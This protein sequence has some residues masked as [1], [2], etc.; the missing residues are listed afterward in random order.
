MNAIAIA[1]SNHI[2]EIQLPDKSFLI[3]FRLVRISFAQKQFVKDTFQEDGTSQLIEI[4]EEQAASLGIHISNTFETN[5]S[6]ENVEETDENTFEPSDDYE[7]VENGTLSFVYRI[8]RPEELNLKVISYIDEA[9]V[10][11]AACSIPIKC[12]YP[13]DDQRNA[14]V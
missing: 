7:E 2:S 14:F 1:N 9:V 8:V 13:E 11:I 5:E 12:I 4:N 3:K 6:S 10:L